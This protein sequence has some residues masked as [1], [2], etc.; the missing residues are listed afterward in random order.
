MAWIA[1]R[2]TGTCA[3]AVRAA[4]FAAAFASGFG[5]AQHHRQHAAPQGH[6]EPSDPASAHGHAMGGHGAVAPESKHYATIAYDDD[7]AGRKG[8]KTIAPAWKTISVHQ[9]TGRKT[10]KYWLGRK[11]CSFARA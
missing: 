11:R 5:Y 2:G 7:A 3:F 4:L 10:R 6:A 9:G 8:R 1:R